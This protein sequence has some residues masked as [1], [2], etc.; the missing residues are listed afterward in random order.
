M[1]DY[2][3]LK[4]IS[5]THAERWEKEYDALLQ[6]CK[7]VAQLRSPH[8]VP[9]E[10]VNRNDAGLYYVTPLANG[11]AAVDPV[12]QAWSPVSL[13]AMIHER[14][15]MPAW[16]SIKE[17]SA[18][19]RPVLDALQTLS[20][21]GLVHRNMKPENTL[22]FNGQPCL[23]DISLLG[24]DASVITRRG[25]PGYA[26]PSWYVGGHPVMYGVAATLYTLLT[27]ISRDEM[28]RAAFLWPPQR[29]CSLSEAERGEWE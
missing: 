18:L 26:T 7:V 8:W 10:H 9:I 27:G 2:R 17:I 19:I 29:E 3:A 14:A 6:F 5:I 20:D 16:F 15:G 1:G 23:G 25:T 28:G 12:N 22:F 24:A 13:A 4:F 11:G 21:A